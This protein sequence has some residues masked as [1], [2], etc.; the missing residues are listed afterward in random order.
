MEAASVELGPTTASDNERQPPDFASIDGNRNNS[1]DLD[2]SFAYVN[3]IAYTNK[4][5]IINIYK[6]LPVNILSGGYMARNECD[7]MKCVR[8]SRYVD[9]YRCN[10]PLGCCW[11]LVQTGRCCGN[12]VLASSNYFIHYRSDHDMLI[13]VK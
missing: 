4:S 6:N 10:G 3:I 12:H 8:Y 7:Y 13:K 1:S 9:C 2:F 11:P 5:L